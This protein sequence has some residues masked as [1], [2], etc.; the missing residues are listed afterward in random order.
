MNEKKDGIQ[1]VLRV[2]F[3][4]GNAADASGMDNHG[5]VSGAPC[6]G[7]GYDGAGAVYIANPFGKGCAQQYITFPDLKGIDLRTDDFTITLW[8][9]SVQGG[10]GEWAPAW[11]AADLGQI[12]MNA[13]RQGG[14]LLSNRDTAGTEDSGFAAV[15]LPQNQFF[16]AGLTDGNGIH[17]DVS[18]IWQPQD[19]RWH[20]LA[21]R[22]DRSGMLD[23]YV[24]GER[25]AS[26]DISSAKGQSL[27]SN[28][29]VLGADLLGQ[30]GLGSAYVDELTLWRG[31]RGEADIR[32]DYQTG[33]LKV[34]CT[35]V[36]ER[37]DRLGEEYTRE[38]KAPVASQCARILES[39][40]G[41][42]GEECAA[43]YS[44]LKQA[45][46]ACLLAPEKDAKLVMLMLSDMHITAPDCA[47]A[48]AL[49]KV[50]AGVEK[51]GVRIDGVVN[52]GDLTSDSNPRSMQTA[53]NVL[54]SLMDSHKDWQMAACFGNHETHYTDTNENYLQSTPVY[55]KNLQPYLAEEGRVYGSGRLD[56]VRN[57]SYGMTFR[58]YHMLVL[59]TD[60]KPQTG[61]SKKIYDEHGNW[62]IE[63]NKLDPIRHGMYLEEQTLDWIR[64]MMDAYSADGLPVFVIG[65]FPFIDSCPLSYYREIVIYDNSIGAQDPQIR[66][67]LAQYRNVIYISGHLHSSVELG[68]PVQVTS[69]EGNSFIQINLPSQKTAARGYRSGTTTWILYVYDKEIVLRTCD[70]A[71]GQ[72]L[73]EYD[74][75]IPLS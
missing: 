22:A 7:Q 9:R 42:N 38:M 60:Y 5:A 25:T 65:H 39:L 48:K 35:E 29:L 41:M 54:N 23:V 75:V 43:A 19:G 57:Y 16:A 15:Q 31:L 66:S 68:R 53:F 51:L 44:A 71:T 47:T 20:L 64:E 70:F 62:S 59:N 37:L 73:T 69:A 30:Y 67:L 3:D 49:R 50:F 46:D 12:D 56:A 40:P 32:A 45:Y 17:M 13:M 2:S 26:A 33:R 63:G 10:I 28:T 27:G 55:W 58:G 24:D 74:H 1:S 6:Y 61:C 18:G 8:Y 52:A 72:W 14:V 4:G 36:R 21:L 34:L 11:N